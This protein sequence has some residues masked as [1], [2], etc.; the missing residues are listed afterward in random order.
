MNDGKIITD[1]IEILHETK[2]FYEELYSCKDTQL[3]GINLHDVLK[4]VEVNNLSPEE[5]KGIDL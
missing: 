3:T 1:Q 4:D 5:S 2:H